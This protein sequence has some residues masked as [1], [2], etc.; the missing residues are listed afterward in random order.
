MATRLLTRR[1]PRLAIALLLTGLV[2]TVIGTGPADAH[3]TGKH[4]V[5]LTGRLDITD[6]DTADHDDV[7]NDVPISREAL[8]EP[9]RSNPNP[10]ATIKYVSDCD[11]LEVTLKLVVRLGDPYNDTSGYVL[12]KESDC[13][14]F[15]THDTIGQKNFRAGVVDDFAQRGGPVTIA[16]GDGRVTAEFWVTI[17]PL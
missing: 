8:I 1:W 15:C 7:C 12:V 16:N 11:E 14:V 17:N 10:S 6:I 13:F 5:R 2:T 9:T 4:I 3:T